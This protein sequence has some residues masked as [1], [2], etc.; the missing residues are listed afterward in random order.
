M[1]RVTWICDKC[2]KKQNIDGLI[3]DEENMPSVDGWV[4]IHRHFD[5]KI[6]DIDLC[7]DCASEVFG[8]N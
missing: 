1:R 6:E 8:N 5:N 4:A 7:P 3:F 2:G